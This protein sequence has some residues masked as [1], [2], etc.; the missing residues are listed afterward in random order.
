MR[1]FRTTYDIFHIFAGKKETNKH[2][3]KQRYT[4]RL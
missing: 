4:Q 2:T 1:D 3:N